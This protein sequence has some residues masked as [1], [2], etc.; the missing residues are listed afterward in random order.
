MKQLLSLAF[1]LALAGTLTACDRPGDSAG[2]G[3]MSAGIAANFQQ[4]S[5][6]TDNDIFTE[7]G[8]AGAG[9]GGGLSVVNPGQDGAPGDLATVRWL[10]P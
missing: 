2:A 7:S 5:Y 3:G 4:L 9:G 6:E 8:M 1:A 10:G